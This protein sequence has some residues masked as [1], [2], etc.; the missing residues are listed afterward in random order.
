[1]TFQPWIPPRSYPKRRKPPPLQWSHDLSAMDTPPGGS[2]TRCQTN[3]FN[4]A[5]TFQPWIR[6]I[7]RIFRPSG[8]V[9]A[10]DSRF[11]RA[12][13]FSIDRCCMIISAF[14]PLFVRALPLQIAQDRRSRIL[15]GDRNRPSFAQSATATSDDQCLPLPRFCL[16]AQSPYHAT[17]S[18]FNGPYIDH[19]HPILLQVDYL[20]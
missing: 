8:T 19:D 17:A 5:M 11:R 10:R 14:C 13:C 7:F 18:P 6:R 4:G 1:M 2:T 16:A 20:R 9:R 12:K 3:T 15:F